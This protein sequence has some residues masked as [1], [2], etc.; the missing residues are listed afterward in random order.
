MGRLTVGA[1]VLNRYP[2]FQVMAF[3]SFPDQSPTPSTSPRIK[4]RK[5]H[6]QP[7]LWAVAT[8]FFLLGS[9]ASV[10]TIWQLHK[11]YRATVAPVIEV[12]GTVQAKY[13]YQ[14]DENELR[15]APSGYFIESQ[16]T[17]R[18]YLTGKPLN[19]YVGQRVQANGSIAGIC[20]PKSLP[21]YP[22]VEVREINFTE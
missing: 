4:V 12:T 16:G 3:T 1:R 8:L 15:P 22:L 7:T 18:V 9:A 10:L 17:G 6:S 2:P 13:S 20:G 11:L 19:S 5:T 21:C 14:E